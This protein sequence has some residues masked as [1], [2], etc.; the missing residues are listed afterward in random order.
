MCADVAFEAIHGRKDLFAVAAH[1]RPVRLR[2]H[3]GGQHRRIDQIGEK[4]CQPAY[5]TWIGGRSQQI[6]GLGIHSISGQYLLRQRRPG[7]PITSVDRCHS[8]IEQMINRRGALRTGTAAF[9]QPPLN[10]VA[11]VN[12]VAL[13]T[14][15]WAVVDK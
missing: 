4:Y 7:D 3:P 6:F 8:L 9:L 5:L 15:T 14:S 13:R 12:I 10:V 1:Q 2:L 11:H